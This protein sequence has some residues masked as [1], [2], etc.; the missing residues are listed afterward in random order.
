MGFSFVR[1][2]CGHLPRSGRLAIILGLGA[3]VAGMVGCGGG[4]SPSSPGGTDAGQGGVPARSAEVSFVIDGTTTYGTL[5]VPSRPGGGDLAA[6][7]L[8][9]GSGPTDRDGDD[10][11]MGF[12]P[13]TLAVI[14]NLLAEDGIA[15]LR[16]DKFFSGK[17]G[18][19]R[20]ADDPGAFTIGAELR[21]ADAA[22]EF[23]ARQ[24][25]VDPSRLLVVGHS[26]GG[27]VA[28]HV[29]DSAAPPPA[30]LALLEPQD[31]RHLTIVRLQTDEAI[32]ARVKAGKV[33]AVQ[34]LRE[35]AKVVRAILAFRQG[36]QPSTAGMSPLVAKILTPEL[37]TPANA[38][39]DRG[40]DAIVP[41]AL[42]A[43]VRP[44][45]RVLVT[46][47][48]RDTNIPTDTLGPLTRALRA[49]RTV[50]PGVVILKG[51][52]HL[53]HLPGQAA[54]EAVLAPA[55]IAAIRAWARPY[56]RAAG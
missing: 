50:G 39:F 29:A 20:Y 55:A 19:G 38:R 12:T 43:R 36:R 24:P 56:A 30:G 8:I 9:P 51:T 4:G 14:A 3:V 44:G 47:G 40:H 1:G 27:M 25:R 54:T 46:D 34:G 35:A 13:D 32:A 23:L 6:A 26:E 53:M 15:S 52:D 33:P 10:P 37:F 16:Y 49:A 22:Y 21:Q 28:L 42:A 11:G 48:T 7:L 5:E 45:T 17:T 31:L 18:A 2:L 41:A